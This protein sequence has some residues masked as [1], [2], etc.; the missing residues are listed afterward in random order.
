MIIIINLQNTKI[1]YR[2]IGIIGAILFNRY[3]TYTYIANII[4][5]IRKESN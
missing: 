5:G 4:I 2:V 3:T 1:R